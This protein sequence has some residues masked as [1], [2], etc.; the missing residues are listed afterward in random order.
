MVEAISVS[1]S[2][3]TSN[4]GGFMKFKK[5]NEDTYEVSYQGK[6]VGTVHKTWTYPGGSGWSY[7]G[8]KVLA[9]Y[10]SRKAAAEALVKNKQ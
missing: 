1:L 3:Q 2:F 8:S 7:R 6:I 5:I 9:N 4:V 10:K